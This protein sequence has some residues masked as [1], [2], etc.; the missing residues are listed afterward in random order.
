MLG[1]EERWDLVALTGCLKGRT[2]GSRAEEVPPLAGA[3]KLIGRMLC[4]GKSSS[5]FIP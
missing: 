4:A 3:L 2:V 1:A 5:H